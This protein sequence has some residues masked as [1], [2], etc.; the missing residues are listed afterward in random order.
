M[1]YVDRLHAAT[2][3]CHRAHSLLTEAVESGTDDDIN[4]GLA[5]FAEACTAREAVLREISATAAAAN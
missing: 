2:A 5:L 4:A 1:T 3:S